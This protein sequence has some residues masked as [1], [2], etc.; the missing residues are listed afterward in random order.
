MLFSPIPLT[1][2]G[3]RDNTSLLLLDTEVVL[4]V[5]L[6]GFGRKL[7]ILESKIEFSYSIFHESLG[8]ISISPL[9]RGDDQEVCRKQAVSHLW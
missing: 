2:T 1:M 9:L 7:A 5:I 4:R 3:F 8:D 6:D